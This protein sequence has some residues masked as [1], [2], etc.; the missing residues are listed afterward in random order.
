M[1]QATD[2]AFKIP[3]PLLEISGQGCY[4]TTY[5]HEPTNF[6]TLIGVDSVHVTT[7]AHLIDLYLKEKDLW[8]N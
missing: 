3:E 8:V 5:K 2:K 4:I 1:D 6:P 7:Q